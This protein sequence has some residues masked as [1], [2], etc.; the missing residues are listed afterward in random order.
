MEA[1]DNK[2]VWALNVVDRASRFHHVG[3]LHDKRTLAVTNALD[4]FWLPWAGV[5]GQFVTDLGPEF[6]SDEFVAWC[7]GHGAKVWHTS[8]E[9]PWQNGLAERAGAIFKGIFRKVVSD[10]QCSTAVELDFAAATTCVAMNDRIN[11]SGYSPS[12]WVIGRC[13]RRAGSL[14]N[15]RVA[16]HLPEHDAADIH[17]DFMRRSAFLASARL[18]QLRLDV[19]VQLRRAELARARSQPGSLRLGPGDAVYFYRE[20]KA[21]NSKLFLKR[22]HGPAT[23]IGIDGTS[24]VYVGYKGNTTKC[25]PEHVRRASP[26]EE[27]A[28][29]DWA[30]ELDA[31][32]SFDIDELDFAENEY[33][34]TVEPTATGG[35]YA[36]APAPWCLRRTTS[37]QVLRSRPSPSP[38]VSLVNFPNLPSLSENVCLRL[39]LGTLHFHRRLIYRFLMHDEFVSIQ[40]PAIQHP[41]PLHLPAPRTILKELR[42]RLVSR[43][44]KMLRVGL[45]PTLPPMCPL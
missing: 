8:V 10:H 12:Q 41:V 39:T 27:L 25:A 30:A 43:F 40:A 22:W 23:V 36:P 19:D 6:R 29:G 11:E 33:P 26:L 21:K 18:A 38:D 5:P 44:S 24:A 16:D 20:T 9:A 35:D 45:P 3:I 31:L 14:L 34:D 7:E 17:P 28:A 42:N 32:A 1:A 15:N 13:P 2:K 4:R 37:L